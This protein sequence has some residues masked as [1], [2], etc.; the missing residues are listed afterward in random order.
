M[1]YSNGELY[2]EILA[3]SKLRIYKIKTHSKHQ[4]IIYVFTNTITC[5]IYHTKKNCCIC[6]FIGMMRTCYCC[7]VY[8]LLILPFLYCSFGH[9]TIFICVWILQ[10]QKKLCIIKIKFI[11]KMTQKYLANK[12]LIFI[13]S[14]YLCLL[15]TLSKMLIYFKKVKFFFLQPLKYKC[16]IF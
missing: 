10:V 4:T 11:K 15:S 12:F 5:K 7:W 2:F 8:F 6:L 14:F 3:I 13:S 16:T 9:R 1:V